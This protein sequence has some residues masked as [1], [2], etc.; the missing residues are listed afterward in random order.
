MAEAVKEKYVNDNYFAITSRDT[1]LSV[2]ILKSLQYCADNTKS[3][4][5]CLELREKRMCSLDLFSTKYKSS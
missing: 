1:S 5:V 2:E 4:T 3:I